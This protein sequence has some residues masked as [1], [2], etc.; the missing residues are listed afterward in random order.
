MQFPHV[1]RW[2]GLC[3]NQE[4]RKI[5]MIRGGDVLYIVLGSIAV[6]IAFVIA[7]LY[8]RDRGSDD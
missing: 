2:E 4:S 3:L 1:T 7:I 8:A 6:V 5:K